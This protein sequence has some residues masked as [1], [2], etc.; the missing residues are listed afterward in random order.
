MSELESRVV[1]LEATQ[2]YHEREINALKSTGAQMQTALNDIKDI[3]K[4]VKWVAVGAVLV[5]I[6]S[7]KGVGS[8]V[9][10]LLL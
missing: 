7:E 8:G 4:Q 1:K 9:W 10:K 3:L 5:I 2:E 6:F